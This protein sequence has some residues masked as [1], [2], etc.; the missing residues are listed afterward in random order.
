MLLPLLILGIGASSAIPSDPFCAYSKER[1][2]VTANLQCVNGV[3]SSIIFAAFGT[4]MG[5]CPDFAHDPKCD[6]TSFLQ[7]VHTSCLGQ[8]SCT[9]QSQGDPC[10]NVIKSIA[11]VAN[12]SE[13]PGGYQPVPLPNPTC[14][15]NRQPCPVPSGWAEKATW[16]LTQ[17]SVI[18][19]SSSDY[20]TPKHP[21]GLVSLD[22]SVAVNQ[23]FKGNTSNTTCEAT[24]VRGC[25]MLK[26]QGL[27]HRCFIY[28]NMELAL[29]WLESQRAVMYDPSTADYFLQYTDGKGQKLGKIY[30]EPITQ[31]DQF[32][33]DYRNPA[34]RAYVITSILEVLQDPMVDGTFTDDVTGLPEEHSQVQSKINISNAELADLQYNTRLASQTLIDALALS[35]KGNWQAFGAEDGI[36][37][38]PTRN[39]CTSFMREFCQPFYQG[40]LML[41]GM[42]TSPANKVQTVAGFLVTRPP[43][44]YLGWGW[45]SGDEK[46][47]DIFLLQ[48]GTP[49]GLCEEISEGVFQRRYSLGIASL[50]CNSWTASLPFPSL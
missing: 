6:D 39:S 21:W 9:V 32:F 1:D 3:I 38:A 43:V 23:W 17:S 25:K 12:C 33:W 11:I 7:Y 4:P 49:L 8:Q 31:G 42:D 28:H 5:S 45:E 13:G 14:A 37:P 26:Q 30:N 18:Q 40:R 29:E 27:A 48:V 36:G 41:M 2:T 10:P 35:G 46:W 34:V 19:P 50:D 20:F 16:N 47:D 15:L 24:S 44:A 22:W